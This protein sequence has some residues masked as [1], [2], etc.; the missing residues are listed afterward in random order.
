VRWSRPIEGTIKTVTIRRDAGQWYVCFSCGIDTPT[1]ARPERPAVGI[2]VGLEHF[3]TLSEGTHIANPRYFR[4]GEAVL[5]RR[6]RILARSFSLPIPCHRVLN[7][8]H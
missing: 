8:A 6:Q 4:R 7:P 1:P 5:A 3:A 2:D